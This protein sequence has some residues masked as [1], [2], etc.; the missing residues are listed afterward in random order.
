MILTICVATFQADDEEDE[1]RFVPDVML[2][3]M[4]GQIDD[5]DQA[6]EDRKKWTRTMTFPNKVSWPVLWFEIDTSRA[7][8]NLNSVSMGGHADSE[9]VALSYCWWHAFWG[10]YFHTNW[11]LQK[12]IIRH[13]QVNSQHHNCIHTYIG[14]V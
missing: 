4:Q 2:E 9:I 13:L 7:L 14:S 1:F 10:Y 3:V 11:V 8:Q 5:I 6:R 12:I